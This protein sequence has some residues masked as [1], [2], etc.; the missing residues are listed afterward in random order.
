MLSCTSGSQLFDFVCWTSALLLPA[1]SDDTS[2]PAL[3]GVSLHRRLSSPTCWSFVHCR[4]LHVLRPSLLQSLYKPFLSIL[5]V[6]QG[7]SV[8]GRFATARLP[9]SICFLKTMGP[10]RL[11]LSSE[12]AL[13]P[14]LRYCHRQHPSVQ[15]DA[16]GALDRR[17]HSLSAVLGHLCC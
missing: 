11:S 13:S 14:N 5:G 10:S 1:A 6:G 2:A 4:C 15:M 7:Q 3:R 9:T 16:G 12:K 17:L 8:D